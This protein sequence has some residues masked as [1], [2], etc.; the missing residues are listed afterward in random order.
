V[1]VI[2]AAA[3][4]LTMTELITYM[5]LVAL[6]LKACV[7]TCMRIEVDRAKRRLEKETGKSWHEL[8]REFYDRDLE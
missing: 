6:I 2:T 5:I 1:T 3:A 8:R 7:I 4:D